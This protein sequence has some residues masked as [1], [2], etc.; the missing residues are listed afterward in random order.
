MKYFLDQFGMFDHSS[1]Q[2]GEDHAFAGQIFAQI[3]VDHA[4]VLE[5]QTGRALHIIKFGL[6]QLRQYDITLS[7]CGDGLKLFQLEAGQARA[8]PGL[9]GRSRPGDLLEGA[10]GVQTKLK[11]PFRFV[12][13]SRQGTNG[14][15]AEPGNGFNNSFLCNNAHVSFSLVFGRSDGR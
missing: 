7:R 3:A 9:I 12:S 11:H 8:P 14:L 15:L 13:G 5:D 4:A 10:P 1:L 6:N 2:V